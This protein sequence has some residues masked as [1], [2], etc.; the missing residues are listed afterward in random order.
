MEKGEKALLHNRSENAKIYRQVLLH[1]YNMWRGIK[2]SLCSTKF[3]IFILCSTKLSP[4]FS[5]HC[6]SGLGRKWGGG[7]WRRWLYYAWWPRHYCQMATA[8]ADTPPQKCGGGWRIYDTANVQ[9]FKN[10]I[11]VANSESN[12]GRRCRTFHCEQFTANIIS[13][14][15]KCAGNWYGKYHIVALQLQYSRPGTWRKI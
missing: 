11:L 15:R 2:Y 14:D 1:M 6:V 7:G 8:S 10:L 12:V 13:Y 4:P 5:P 9:Y 3:I